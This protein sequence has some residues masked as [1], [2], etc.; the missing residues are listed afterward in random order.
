MAKKV[1]IG[2]LILIVIVGGAAMWVRSALGTDPVKSA[3]AS[4]LSKAIGQPVT[5]EGVSAS[6]Y[7]RVTIALTGVSIG[8]N[9]RIRLQSLDIGTA[10]G[11]L[12]SRRIEHATLR[13]SDARLELPLP[14]LT[15]ASSQGGDG[16]SG[17][18]PVQLISIDEIV[19]QN[20]ELVSRGRTLRGDIEIVPHGT[21]ALTLRKIALTADGARIDATGEI[22]NLAGPT[23]TIDIKAGALDL[24]QLTAFASDFAEGSGMATGAG[25][26]GNTPA[27]STAN[28]AAG[29]TGGTAPATAPPPASTHATGATPDLTLTLAADKASMAGVTLERV[30]GRAHLRGEQLTVEPMSFGVFGGTYEGSLGASFGAAPTFFWKAQLREVDVAAVTAFVGNPGVVTGR[31]A[32]QIDLTGQGLDAAAAMKTARGTARLA[33][34]NGIVKNLALVKSAVAA[35]SLNPQAVIASS[36]GPLDEP[37]SELGA[38]LSIAA[39][40][41]STPD[42]HFVSKDIRLD[43]GGALRLDGGAVNLQGSVQMSEEL[44]KQAQATFVRATQQDGKITLPVTVR[45]TAGKYSIEIDTA[46]LAKRAITNEAKGQAQEAVKK[47][48][49]RLLGR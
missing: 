25:S 4:Q 45:G 20:V 24:D 36:Q 43:A 12:L 3:L 22:T 7:P 5:I 41:A 6:I 29:S 48:L 27:G 28:A 9:G 8:D 18:S 40:T 17:G 39:G 16:S 32:A 37:F 21:S 44:S 2:V 15:I 30:S 33:I 34:T 11:A 26:A 13:L 35:T 1:A 23:G 19:L 38:S 46:S 49:G 31:M 47:G 42:L 10:L 14:P